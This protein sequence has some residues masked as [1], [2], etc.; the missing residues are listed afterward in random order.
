MN[1]D[2]QFLFS[3]NFLAAC[4][5]IQPPVPS[6]TSGR[7]DKL[8]QPRRHPAL[9]CRQFFCFPRVSAHGSFSWISPSIMNI[10]KTFTTFSPIFR[11]VVSLLSR[12]GV[13]EGS[14]F[15]SSCYKRLQKRH[16]KGFK[17]DDVK[18]ATREV[19]CV[20]IIGIGFA[21]QIQQKHYIVT[22]L[23]ERILMIPLNIDSQ[24]SLRILSVSLF[25]FTFFDAQ[26]KKI[27]LPSLKGMESH[28]EQYQKPIHRRGLMLTVSRWRNIS[29]PPSGQ[30]FS[31][32]CKLDCWVIAVKIGSW[33]NTPC[34]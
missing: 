10:D 22:I 4:K 23:R 11:H 30:I 2:L 20:P 3:H 12:A 15:R 16:L 21:S 14:C 9:G 31:Y 25:F 26:V 32:S 33:C 1:W 19:I 13:R 8:T 34:L 24:W 7:F 27:W 28:L 17:D 18:L 6:T 29:C 5:Y